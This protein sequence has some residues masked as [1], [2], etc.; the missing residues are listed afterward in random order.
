MLLAGKVRIMGTSI[1]REASDK[2]HTFCK[3]FLVMNNKNMS[4]AMLGLGGL[5]VIGVLAAGTD[6]GR[7]IIRS[8]IDGF[9][10]APSRIQGWNEAAQD[11]LE[12]IQA[13]INDLADALGTSHVTE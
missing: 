8:L 11:E 3:V 4:L 2:H 13:A 9:S 1:Q 6:R 12:N 5:G 7:S 10:D